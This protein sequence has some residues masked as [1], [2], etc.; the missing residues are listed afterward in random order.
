MKKERHPHSPDSPERDE[1]AHRLRGQSRKITGPRRA[2]MELLR[3]EK[4]PLTIR[5]IHGSLVENACDLAT[6][7]RSMRMLEEMGLVQRFDFGDGI[8]RFELKEPEE[9]SH[10]HHLICRE[11]TAVVEIEEC[12]P[13]ELEE[14]I[15]AGNGFAGFSHRLEFFGI[16]PKCQEK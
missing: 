13:A 5:E 4:H 10:H 6:V 12:F 3:R 1:F 16:C 14:K 8:A 11:C 2:I 15:A 9:D 7:Y